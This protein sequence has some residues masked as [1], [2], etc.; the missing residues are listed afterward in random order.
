MATRTE[1][2]VCTRAARILG[3]IAYDEALGDAEYIQAQEVYI[4]L[5]EWMR[6]EL[7]VRWNRDNVDEQYFPMV[8]AILAGWLIGDLKPSRE[9]A[10]LVTA[11]AQRNE[12]RLRQRLAKAPR[13]T[14]QVSQV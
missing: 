6:D 7:R 14:V 1:L 11:N 13:K 2:D 4:S 3:Y 5:H 10:E 8:A 9:A 12:K